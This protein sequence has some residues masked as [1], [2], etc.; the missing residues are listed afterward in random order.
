MELKGKTQILNEVKKE[1][2]DKLE[3]YKDRTNHIIN[4]NMDEEMV[5]FIKER[6]LFLQLLQQL[7]K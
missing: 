7:D 5:E 2:I 3:Q 4:P 1:L 6:V